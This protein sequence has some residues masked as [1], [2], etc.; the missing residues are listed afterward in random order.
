[1][2]RYIFPGAELPS[3]SEVCAVVERSGLWAT[4]IEILR[5]HY[6]DT[7]RCWRERFLA[8]WHKIEKLYDARFC[9]MW[10]YYLALCEIGFR[11]RTNMVFQLQI[12]KRVDA[13]P[14]NRDYMVDIERRLERGDSL[15]DNV[16][17]QTVTP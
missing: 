7:L 15:S 10:E 1:M 4:D 12:A 11:R 16:K 3:L 2:R 13:A 14:I 17:D 5:L 9:R 8:Q 6:A